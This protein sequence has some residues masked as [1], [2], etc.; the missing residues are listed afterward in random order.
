MIR[1]RL[2]RFDSPSLSVPPRQAVNFQRLRVKP[3]W[4]NSERGVGGGGGGSKP[5]STAAEKRGR[6]IGAEAVGCLETRVV[7]GIDKATHARTES[8][9]MRRN[10][11]PPPMCGEWGG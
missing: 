10:P 11:P 2:E 8:G 9:Y 7:M 4:K 6:R 3:R 1:A 5:A